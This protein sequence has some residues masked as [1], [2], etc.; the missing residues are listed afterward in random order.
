MSFERSLSDAAWL[1]RARLG[2]QQSSREAEAIKQENKARPALP[3]P[4]KMSS[5]GECRRQNT[6]L[7]ELKT[8]EGTANRPVVPALSSLPAS[9]K[10]K[11]KRLCQHQA[12]V[13]TRNHAQ[14]F[15]FTLKGKGKDTTAT[16]F[17]NKT[18]QLL[19]CVSHLK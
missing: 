1:S 19:L 5:K 16:F 15:Q 11:Q 18:A 4:T 7:Q 14:S 10:H 17:L 8:E 12:R 6:V 13:L 3:S 9:P 2:L